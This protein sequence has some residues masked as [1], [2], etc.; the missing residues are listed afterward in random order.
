M[1]TKTNLYA[2]VLFGSILLL[3]GLS[4]LI[5]SLIESVSHAPFLA[6]TIVQ[7]LVYLL[8]L[9]FYFQVRNL[10]PVSV[11]KIRYVQPK[12][13]PF[14]L[15]LMLIFFVGTLVFRYFGLFF[16]RSAFVDTPGA[17]S[18]PVSGANRFF[19]LLCSVI[20]PAVLEEV[21]FR[22]V[23]LE[24]YRSHGPLWAVLITSLMFAMLHLSLANFFYYFFM[25]IVFGMIAV[26]SDS[27]VPCV[28]LHVLTNFSYF[29]L[30]PAIVEY[31][32]QAGKSP[33]LPY[34]L[35][36]VF[37]FLFVMLF[38]RLENLYQDKAYEEMLQSR[39]EL[40][41]QEVEKAR[42]MKE[43]IAVSPIYVTLKEIFL[44]PTFLAT[45]VLFVFLLF[46]FFS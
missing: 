38:S 31:L 21:V 12:K 45:V 29:H 22:S 19:I 36:A 18:V 4:E 42:G 27:I 15:V 37:L 1:K 43:E 32:R 35:V 46:G 34:L 6:T 10:N 9:A 39:K 14:L 23:L 44:S 20:L 2:P 40:L 7:L 16:F 28:L 17:V 13:F 41:R 26:A 5:L 11:V 25:G 24:E 30:R 3:A 33:L 8:P